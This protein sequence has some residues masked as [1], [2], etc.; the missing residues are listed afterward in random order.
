MT[1]LPDNFAVDIA[2]WLLFDPQNRTLEESWS[3]NVKNNFKNTFV[4]SLA[5]QSLDSLEEN[6]PASL[7]RLATGFKFSLLRG[8]KLDSA[9][10]SNL[11]TLRNHLNNAA[12]IIEKRLEELKTSDPAYLA[13]VGDLNASKSKIKA[14]KVAMDTTRSSTE[15]VHLGNLRELEKIHFKNLLN[16]KSLAEEELSEKAQDEAN[17]NY[18]DVK[19]VVSSLKMKRYG[20]KLDLAG[21]VVFDFPNNNFDQGDLS[22][23]G[24][25]L[26][27]GWEWKSEFSFLFLARFLTNPNLSYLDASETLARKDVQNIDLGGKVLY[28]TANK[29]FS[30]SL[31]FIYRDYSEKDVTDGLRATL[32]MSYDVGQNRKLGLALGRDFDG[33]ISESGNVIAAVNLLMGFASK[34]KL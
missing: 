15:K 34:R 17:E 14:L 18:A 4:F 29:K 32:N 30:S 26:T 7:R 16:Q 10:L 31:E 27:S 9:Y 8:K 21:G 25:W 6:N 33:T 19:G 24:I 1:A 22:R 20:F 3:N 23:A 2:P 11:D 12:A 28:S 5:T 13:V